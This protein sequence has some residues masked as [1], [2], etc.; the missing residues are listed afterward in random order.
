MR[1]ITLAKT[2][3]EFDITAKRGSWRLL[4]GDQAIGEQEIHEYARFQSACRCADQ[5]RD[6]RRCLAASA[7]DLG[8]AV[9]FEVTRIKL[10]DAVVA[11]PSEET[12]RSGPRLVPNHAH[13]ELKAGALAPIPVVCCS[14]VA[15]LFR[16]LKQIEQILGLSLD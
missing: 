13:R 3:A 10:S 7:L 11:N 1:F 16:L 2:V 9:E 15:P 6:L 8:A 12:D 5:R 14:H 4:D